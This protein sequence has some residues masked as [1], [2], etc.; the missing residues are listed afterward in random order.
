MKS[1]AKLLYHKQAHLGVFLWHTVALGSLVPPLL[2]IS[3]L[4]TSHGGVGWYSLRYSILIWLNILKWANPMCS[5]IVDRIRPETTSVGTALPV[6]DRCGNEV[7]GYSWYWSGARAGGHGIGGGERKEWEEGVRG[8]RGTVSHSQDVFLGMKQWDS[9]RG[10]EHEGRCWQ[11]ISIDFGFR[12]RLKQWRWSVS[13]SRAPSFWWARL[14]MLWLSGP[15]PLL[16]CLNTL[17][18]CVK[19]IENCSDGFLWYWSAP[20]TQIPIISVVFLDILFWYAVL[21]IIYYHFFHLWES[22]GQGVF[23]LSSGKPFAPFLLSPLSEISLSLACLS[24]LSLI[25]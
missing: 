10:F 19:A 17:F 8:E 3:S 1:F 16:D 6:P 13:W 12:N 5:T 2:F 25:R 9:V 20:L 4:L 11:G 22:P 21:F 23:F 14:Q 24:D 7:R 18:W 15:L